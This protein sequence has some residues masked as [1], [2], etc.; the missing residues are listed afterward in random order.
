DVRVFA[1]SSKAGSVPRDPV[2]LLGD[3]YAQGLG[4]WLWDTDPGW[5]RPFSSA[6]VINA[7]TGRDV[8]TLGAS[9][10][11]SAEGVARLPAS[12]YRSTQDAWYLRL[13]P[14]RVAVIYFYEGNDLNDN[15]RFLASRAQAIDAADPAERIDRA[16][17]AYPPPFPAPAGW[18]HHLPLF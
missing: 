10:A 17:A 7:V 18:S 8:I 9:G 4:D 5:N 2:I 12:A 14:P 6:H 16:I 15:L 3:S 11:G 13:P 1:Q